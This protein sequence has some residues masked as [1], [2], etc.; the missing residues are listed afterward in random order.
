MV[1]YCRLKDVDIEKNV[2][3]RVY[4]IF[5]ARNVDVRPQKDG[6]EYITLDM[7][8]N[9]KVVEA[10]IFS[11][12]KATKEKIY[13][14][15]VYKAA[16]D[17][18]TYKKN[19]SVLLSCIIYSIDYCDISTIEFVEK[20]ENLEYFVD[21]IRAGLE[22]TKGTVY[23]AITTRI[24]GKHWEKFSIWP[25]GK[26]IHHTEIGGLV[27]HTAC[28]LKSAVAIGRVYNEVYGDKFVNMP[29][30]ASAAI[31]HDVMK[32]REFEL[33]I[34]SGAV[35]YSNYGALSSHILECLREIDLEAHELGIENTEEITLLK[36][37][38]AAHHGKLEFGSPVKA[39]TTEAIILSTADSQ[40]AEMWQ[41][42][43]DIKDVK[44]GSHL[45]LWKRGELVVRY[46]DTTKE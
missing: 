31:L 29:L 14:G 13:E 10:K 17:I 4:I 43:R 44:A 26:S 27:M 24:L 21:I 3:N 19:G 46:K 32:T 7:V 30:L 8:D 35:T 40:D 39:C 36:H 6:G 5:M 20:V 15:G 42:N 45:A 1:E 41:F 34:S 23:E 2:G 22:L 33:D 9:D 25:A 37:V 18:K 12:N 16:V 28:V 11:I 38:I